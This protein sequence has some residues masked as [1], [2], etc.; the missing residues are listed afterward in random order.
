M[1]SEE[2]HGFSNL[3]RNLRDICRNGQEVRFNTCADPV[4]GIDT[5]LN[6]TRSSQ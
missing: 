4:K 5:D 6:K 3:D 1:N 2:W